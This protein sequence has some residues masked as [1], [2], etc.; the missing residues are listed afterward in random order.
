MSLSELLTADISHQGCRG[1][2]EVRR[3]SPTLGIGRGKVLS[4]GFLNAVIGVH[5]PLTWGQEER[6]HRHAATVT[7]TR[8]REG[9]MSRLRV[10]RDFRPI[11]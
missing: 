9:S 6:Q 5:R 10:P 8:Q 11:Q 3:R 7:A 2:A 4:I 1:V